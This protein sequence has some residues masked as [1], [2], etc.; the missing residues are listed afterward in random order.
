[1]GSRPKVVQQAA[2]APTPGM[3]RYEEVKA[4]EEVTAR[5]NM[6]KRQKGAVN[7]EATLLTQP[8]SL[9]SINNY[10]GTADPASAEKTLLGQ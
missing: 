10:A 1:M 5:K 4:D 2:P 9:L 3:P 7:T 6:R 8:P